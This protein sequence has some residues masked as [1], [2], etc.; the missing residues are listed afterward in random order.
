MTKILSLVL[1]R[2]EL[3]EGRGDLRG[4]WLLCSSSAEGETKI[5]VG[6]KGVLVFLSNF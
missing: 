4:Q 6:I 1:T 5:M 2:E 3:L